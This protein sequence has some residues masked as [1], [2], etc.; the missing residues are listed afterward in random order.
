M[1]E[2]RPRVRL[3]QIEDEPGIGFE[4]Y[5]VRVGITTN[6]PALLSQ[7][8]EILPPSARECD[9]DGVGH[10]FRL[11]AKDDGRF[12]LQIKEN[13]LTW[14]ASL[15]L[16]MTMLDSHLQEVVALH[17]PDLIF[18]HAGAVAHN[19]RC[20]L[21]PGASFAGKST[22]V[23]ALVRAGATYYSDD[24]APLDTEGRVHPYPKPLSIRDPELRATKHDAASL[25]AKVG[26]EPLPV[27]AIA[28]ARYSPGVEWRPAR[29]SPGEAVLG[30]LSHTVPAQE[31]PAESL[32]A[33]RQAVQ[34]ATVLEGERDDADQL[35]PS[36]LAELER[37]H[38]QFS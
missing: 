36:L 10:R 32:T 34:D 16:A 5:G 9:L 35:A 6:D 38:P 33:I 3:L 1:P 37:H 17:A 22:L 18:V 31:R 23:A 11:H 19:G 29:L 8:E 25:G 28:I 26:Q 21:V 20:L 7:V 24:F 30:L 14:D 13:F 4:A 15:E 2:S 27:G 12:D